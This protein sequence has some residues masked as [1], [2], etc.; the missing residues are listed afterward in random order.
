MAIPVRNPPPPYEPPP[1]SDRDAPRP[2]TFGGPADG[3]EPPRA[4]DPRARGCFVVLGIAAALACIASIGIVASCQGCMHMA[5]A[6]ATRQVAAGYRA[7]TAGSATESTDLEDLRDLEQ[8]GDS[9]SI[10][11]IAF[12]VLN[13]RYN[14]A[15][16]NDGRI[17]ADELHLG[18]ELVRD[19]VNG[20]GSIDPERYP[21]GR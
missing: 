15:I 13:N 8:L 1:R 2:P 10:S 20:H 18:M 3:R 12:G 14:E 9:G 17:D 21:A 5:E 4:M 6:Q 11:I 19:I 7:A 16:A